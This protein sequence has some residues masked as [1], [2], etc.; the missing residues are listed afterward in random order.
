MLLGLGV[1]VGGIVATADPGKA[2]PP[3]R[4]WALTR[5]VVIPG[6]ARVRAPRLEVDSVGGPQLIIGAHREGAEDKEW[7]VFA[8]RDTAWTPHLFTGVRASFFPEPV[9]SLVP[10]QFLVWISTISYP[11]GLA[12]LL[13]SRLLPTPSPVETVLTTFVQDTE[14][15]AAVSRERRW[16]AR[17]QQRPGTFNNWVRVLYSDTVGIWR[18]LP[19]APGSEGRT[20]YMCTIA[21]LSDRSAIVAYSDNP[22][23]NWAIVDGDGWAASGVLDPGLL[24]PPLHPRFRFRPSGGLWLMWTNRYYVHIS[25]Y[26]DGVWERGDSVTCVHAPGETFWSAWSDMSRDSSER[27]VLAWGDLGV[28]QTFYDVGCV[29]FPTDSGWAKGEEIPGSRGLFLT[30]KVTRDRNGDAWLV[31][32]MRGID[33][34]LFTHTYVSATTST[35]TIRKE[36]RGRVVN[37]TLS[38]PAPGSWWTV[39]RSRMR[40]PFEAVASWTDE[41]VARVQAGPQ[42]AMSWTDESPAAGLLRY[43][44]GRESVDQRYQWES[45]AGFWPIRVPTPLRLTRAPQGQWAA[46]EVWLELEGAEAGPVEVALYDLQGRQ[47]LRVPSKSQGTG[48]DSIRLDL[49]GAAHPLTPGVY[50]ATAAVDGGKHRSGALKVVVLK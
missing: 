43:R 38:E 33:R 46:D 24:G 22:G 45:G 48:K 37:W 11:D 36:G 39:L 19:T 12:P 41:V 40:G 3:G 21:P 20:S 16:V 7:S 35:P 15:G 31:W 47:V 29:A 17:C 10:G 50:F 23:L 25:S 44:I 4:S 14:Y 1:I 28:G 34:T 30:P 2:L 9:L 13:F 49:G 5:Q 42:V 8:W 27:P 26:R 18:E 32:D 6:V